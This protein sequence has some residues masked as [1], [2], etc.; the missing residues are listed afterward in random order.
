VT[1]QNILALAARL[2][3][4][5]VHC[6]SCNPI[7]DPE[8]GNCE[9]SGFLWYRHGATLSRSGLLRLASDSRSEDM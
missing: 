1:T 2:G 8:C 7:I 3:F 9:G 4:E 5:P 6:P